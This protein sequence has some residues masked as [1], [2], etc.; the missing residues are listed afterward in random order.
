MKPLTAAELDE[1]EADNDAS[2]SR[3]M[4]VERATIWRLIAMA[5]KS[6]EPKRCSQ[7]GQSY[8]APAC[9]FS[10]ATI[11]AERPD[12]SGEYDDDTLLQIITE[13][14]ERSAD[15]IERR[16]GLWLAEKAREARSCARCGHAFRSH[17]EHGCCWDDPCPYR[18]EQFVKVLPPDEVRANFKKAVKGSSRD[19]VESLT[20]D[21]K[22]LG[23]CAKNAP[24]FD[25]EAELEAFKDRMRM[26]EYRTNAGP[27]KDAHAAFR[28]HMRK[29]VMYGTKPKTSKPLMKAFAAI[30]RKD[31]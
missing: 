2:P 7:C 30:D 1:L 3:Q 11:Q 31:V 16:D 27:V 9:G 29:A 10:H 28:T 13:R 14:F 4:L 17:N 12:D 8:D 15:S 26:S 19:L 23:W 18:C 22:M 24:G 20:L 25:A 21:A 6:L 5:R